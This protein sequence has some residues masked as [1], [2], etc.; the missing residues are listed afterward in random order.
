MSSY[1]SNDT[2]LGLVLERQSCREFNFLQN[3]LCLGNFW[4]SMWELW[5]VK[6]QLTSPKE[7]SKFSNFWLLMNLVFPWWIMINPW[8]ND[9]YDFKRLRLTKNLEVWLSVDHSWLFIPHN[10]FSIIWAI[11][12]ANLWTKAWNL[13]WRL[14]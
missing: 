5:L 13:T 10:W 1:L 14:F 6:V 7:M 12:W 9:E 4:W 11:D 3:R 2:F 8:S